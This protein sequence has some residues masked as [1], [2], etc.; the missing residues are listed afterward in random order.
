V[1]GLGMGLVM[2]LLT[3]AL[4]ESFPKTEL[5][6]VTSSSQFFRQIGGTFG[7]TILGAVLNN[8]SSSLLTDRLD[9]VLSHM[10]VG[11]M[12]AQL[13]SMVANNAQGL[14]SSLLNPD[15]VAKMPKAFVEQIV[16]ILKSSLVDSLQSVF[17]FG[18][19]FILFGTALTLF[20]GQIKI[21]DRKDKQVAQA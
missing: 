5:G 13:H 3:I 9:P 16:P 10:P 15:A 21:S 8:R 14:Y 17:L 7:M 18:L 1:L 6:V 11:G 20:L 19:V 12:A 4:Q 2:P